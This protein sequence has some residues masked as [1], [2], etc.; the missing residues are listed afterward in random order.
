LKTKGNILIVGFNKQ[1]SAK[2]R[3]ILEA[4][5]FTVD[6]AVN[7]EKGILCCQTNRYD[8]AF[9]DIKLQNVSGREI[10]NK[11]NKNSPSTDCIYFT[12]YTSPMS[13]I[14]TKQ[15]KHEN[16]SET[17]PLEIGRFLSIIEQIIEQKNTERKIKR[18]EKIKDSIFKLTETTDSTQNLKE[19]T[20]SIHRIIGELILAN[21]YHIALC[22]NGNT[23]H[24]VPYYFENNFHKFQEESKNE[25]METPSNDWVGVPVKVKN[26]VIG[27][28]VVQGYVTDNQFKESNKP[29]I[30]F[31]S[32]QLVKEIGHNEL[33]IK[34]K[35]EIKEK[36]LLIKE[37]HHHFCNNQQLI[38]SSTKNQTEDNKNV[39]SINNFD[40]IRNR[41]Y[42][43]ALVQRELYKSKNQ[44]SINCKA[45]IQK[46]VN[47]L[48]MTYFH[49]MP[50]L[51][52]KLNIKNTVLDIDRAILCG[53]I[54]NELI[55]NSLKHAFPSTW[56]DNKMISVKFCPS[57]NNHVE[58][59]VSDNGVGLPKDLDFRN[60]KSI[61]LNLVNIFENQLNGKITLD[62]Q[63]G[64]GFR[65]S[66]EKSN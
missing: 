20:R 28:L 46:I 30:S 5:Q 14:E 9:V 13:S 16:F 60:T 34:L 36:N 39:V 23:L 4:N 58:L 63:S 38:N 57:N 41:V 65:I 37:I 48:Y 43:I 32:K 26:K 33:K 24:S 18:I 29:I 51:N 3:A 56:E 49:K 47:G 54:L 15:Q 50:G 62:R 2:L 59:I 66:F 11:I 21:N 64:T 52:L 22:E 61:G 35:N 40:E 19:L 25:L 10:V 17:K 12:D 53:L 55:S 1:L 27:A 8:I 45:I 42:P 31:V 6:Y 7:A 44:A